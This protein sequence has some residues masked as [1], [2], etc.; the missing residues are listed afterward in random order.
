M[1]QGDP[2]VLAVMNAVLSFSF[3]VMVVWGLEFVGLSE[4]TWTNVGL[5]TVALFLITWVVILRE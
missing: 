3:T 2:R 5:G 1:S 4:F